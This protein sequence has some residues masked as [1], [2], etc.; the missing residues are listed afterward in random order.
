MYTT[1]YTTSTG[2]GKVLHEWKTINQVSETGI[3]KFTQEEKQ[4]QRD[5]ISLLQFWNEITT[6]YNIDYF[7]VCGTLIGAIR[8]NGL[9]PWDDDIDV[10]VK[11]DYYDQMKQ[12][13]KLDFGQ[14][15][16]VPDL[17]GFS[18][19]KDNSYYPKIDVFIM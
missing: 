15:K 5:L 11:W 12:L 13:T 16:I 17:C 10:G 7:A 19:I 2:K 18:V 1:K 8:N 14:Y 3:I 4:V 6:K 9:I